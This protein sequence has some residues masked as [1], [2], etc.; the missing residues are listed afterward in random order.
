MRTQLILTSNVPGLG[1]E[2][3]QVTVAGGYARNFLL[4]KNMAMIATPAALRRVESLKLLSAE[5]ERKELE[6]AQEL[7]KKISKLQSSVELQSGEDGK[8]FG[9]VTNADIASAMAARGFE[10]D[11]KWVELA[12]PIRKIG[13]YEIPIR[14][15]SQVKA[16][17]KLTVASANQP[18]PVA[19]PH[20]E[21]KPKASKDP[22]KPKPAGKKS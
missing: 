3:D 8:L 11:H 15:H 4:P 13:E 17:F 1:T 9:S 14:L 18:A 2:G 19:A 12:E 6:H 16:T 5:R 22:A 10:I 20:K 21:A 7:A